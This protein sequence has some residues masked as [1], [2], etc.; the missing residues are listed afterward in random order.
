MT[1][2]TELRRALTRVLEQLQPAFFRP[3]LGILKHRAM[4]EEIER[5]Q[6]DGYLIEKD[7]V[8]HAENSKELQTLMDK[9]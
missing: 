9:K 1:E 3:D 4:L 7:G 2:P 8:L 5:L 6:R